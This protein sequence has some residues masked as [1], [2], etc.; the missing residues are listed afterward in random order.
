MNNEPTTESPATAAPPPPQAARPLRPP[1]SPSNLL[2]PVTR[3]GRLIAAIQPGG[4]DL[5]TEKGRLE[6]LGSF[7][8]DAHEGDDVEVLGVPAP[9]SRGS[10]TPALLV[11]ELRR[12]E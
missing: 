9:Q 11:R 1:R 7:D 12:L 5:L 10:A 2:K 8:V 6:L 4:L 3:R